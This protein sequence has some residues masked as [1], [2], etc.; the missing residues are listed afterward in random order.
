[1]DLGYFGAA[2]WDA[3]FPLLTFLLNYL[4][5]SSGNLL[6]HYAI[7]RAPEELTLITI[8]LQLPTSNDL[9]FSLMSTIYY[10][11]HF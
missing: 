10:L 8:C 6:G 1:M 9:S 5:F 2:H 3:Q 4:S 7:Q 11:T